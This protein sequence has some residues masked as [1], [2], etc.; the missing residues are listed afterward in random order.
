MQSNMY[1]YDF[2]INDIDNFIDFFI[3]SHK[4][5]SFDEFL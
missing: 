3:V 1:Y 4:W 2:M 5:Q